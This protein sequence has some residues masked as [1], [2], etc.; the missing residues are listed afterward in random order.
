[1]TKVASGGA[2]AQHFGQ[3]AAR[4]GA[5]SAGAEGCTCFLTR[6]VAAC[7]RANGWRALFVVCGE[8]SCALM[9]C[10]CDNSEAQSLFVELS[11]LGVKGE[12]AS[13]YWRRRYPEVSSEAPIR[14]LGWPLKRIFQLVG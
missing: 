12:R 14:G 5:C 7:V 10:D 2:F 11:A 9:R 8:L 4:R 1:M 6:A 13:A 3:R